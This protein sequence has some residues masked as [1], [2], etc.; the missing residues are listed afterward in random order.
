MRRTEASKSVRRHWP[1]SARNLP[2][3]HGG[4]INL[5]RILA[6][7]EADGLAC[8]RQRGTDGHGSRV[9]SVVPRRATEHTLVGREG[10]PWWFLSVTAH[11][12][13]VTR[14]RSGRGQQP[15]QRNPRA[16]E[17]VRRFPRRR[18]PDASSPP[19]A[20][21]PAVAR[22]LLRRRVARLPRGRW[23]VASPARRPAR[24]HRTV[25]RADRTAQEHPVR[26]VRQGLRH[27][28]HDE[29]NI[30][31]AL[32]MDQARRSAPDLA[33]GLPPVR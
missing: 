15:T 11:K 30:S 21:N 33:S 31:P 26:G 20:W 17:K 32:G 5:R 14:L 25:D 23:T 13:G 9:G 29:R 4:G 27:L 12:H 1:H 24:I 2:L 28:L 19:R 7:P 22:R 10:M 3:D 6:Y 8:Q 18:S 16:Q